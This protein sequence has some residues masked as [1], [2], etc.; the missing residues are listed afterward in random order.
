MFPL[1]RPP[2]Y[3][4]PQTPM[5]IPTHTHVHKH[6]YSSYTHLAYICP[7]HTC[8]HIPTP[9]IYM[10]PYTHTWSSISIHAYTLM[11]T[12][13][14]HTPHTYT[15]HFFYSL[16]T[17]ISIYSYPLHHCAPTH[18]HLVLKYLLIYTLIP[19]PYILCHPHA[20]FG[21]LGC[22]SALCLP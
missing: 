15:T 4:N 20:Y 8:I 12:P 13:H 16:Y 5:H 9:Q 10:H 11:H 2:L 7:I 3:T 19:F 6:V 17:Y 21:D 22:P 1:I 18:T 14:L